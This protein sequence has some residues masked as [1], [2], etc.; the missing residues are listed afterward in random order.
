MKSVIILILSLVFTFMI[1]KKTNLK[2][3]INFSDKSEYIPIIT[4]N[5][6][7]DLLIVFLTFSTILYNSKTLT[8]W[9]KKYR[10]SAM[11]ADIL[12]GILYILLARYIVHKYKL[13]VN[14]FT[15]TLL[16]ILVQTILDYAFYL[17][18]TSVP[19][20]HNDMLDFFK[21]YAKEVK[22]NA[23]L[24]DSIL[25]V[26]GVVLSAYLNTKSFDFNIV[27]LLIAIYLVPYI[28]YYKK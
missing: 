18:F 1:E 8:S 20:G 26:V 25:I 24:G 17:F 16:A 21:N 27:S 3:T 15:F 5:I 4:S 11:I 10:L 7:A 19:K 28:I 12:I 9:Y 22:H 23:L 13:K 14:L 6:Y 2:P